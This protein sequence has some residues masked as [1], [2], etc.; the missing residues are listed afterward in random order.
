MTKKANNI[1]GDVSF[2]E[3]DGG[4]RTMTMGAT[5]PKKLTKLSKDDSTIKAD[6]CISPT[7]RR[8][9]LERRMTVDRWSGEVD[10]SYVALLGP[11]E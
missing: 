7:N 2:I 11:H 5:H 3:T 4:Y 1:Y 8:E 6:R 9:I 10:G